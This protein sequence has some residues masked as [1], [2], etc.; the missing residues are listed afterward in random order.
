MTSHTLQDKQ[1]LHD[2][3]FLLKG[4]GG[5]GQMSSAKILGGARI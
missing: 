3:V 4:G 5:G 1:C 2:T